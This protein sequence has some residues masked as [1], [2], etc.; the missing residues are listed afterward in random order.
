M[1]HPFG[2]VSGMH[3]LTGDSTPPSRFV[4][5]AAYV[6]AV[7]R[8]PYGLPGV[9][10]MDHVMNNFNIP[11]GMIQDLNAPPEYTLWTSI[12]DLEPGRYYIKTRDIP[13]LSEAGFSDFNADVT[14][15]VHFAMLQLQVPAELKPALAG[16]RSGPELD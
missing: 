16:S 1:V 8:A 5:A 10:L 3:V 12:T 4:R 6:L 7:D 15:P 13:A 2:N 9:W 14:T 11:A